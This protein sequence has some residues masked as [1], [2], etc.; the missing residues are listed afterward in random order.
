MEAG[1]RQPVAHVLQVAQTASVSG[2]YQTREGAGKRMVN[3][4]RSRKHT[5][6]SDRKHR[7]VARGNVQKA[8][9]PIRK[10]KRSDIQG[11]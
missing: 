8:E 4:A 1:G 9:Q 11:R 3:K 2:M 5:S 6:K 10:E 7:A